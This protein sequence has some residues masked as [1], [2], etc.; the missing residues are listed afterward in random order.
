[1]HEKAYS[2]LKY[3]LNVLRAEKANDL[4]DNSLKSLANYN[5]YPNY[6]ILVTSLS[7]IFQQ[8]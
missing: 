1:M 7:G 5:V 6:V 4:G 2:K 3:I 8:H